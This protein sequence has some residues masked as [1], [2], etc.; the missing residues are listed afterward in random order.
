MKIT[1]E[2]FDA[3]LF[4]IVNE[5]QTD[6]LF[7]IPGIYE[8]LSEHYN[9]E[10]IERAEEQHKESRHNHLRAVIA[11][12]SLYGFLCYQDAPY[13]GLTELT[14]RADLNHRRARARR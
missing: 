2:Q 10:A 13:N 7:S 9:N 6:N 14:K 12:I 5:E 8:I 3:A 4:D 1:Q 11:N